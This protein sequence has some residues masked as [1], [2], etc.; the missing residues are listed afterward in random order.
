M[1]GSYI[2]KLLLF[3]SG[4]KEAT[5][6]F[7]DGEV[8]N[9]IRTGPEECQF[10]KEGESPRYQN[11]VFD[12]YWQEYEQQVAM[13]ASE[14]IAL[15]AIKGKSPEEW[16]DEIAYR[17]CD[18]AGYSDDELVDRLASVLVESPLLGVLVGT[19]II[20]DEYFED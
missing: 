18:D 14:G 17:L 5:F 1:D 20:E 16:A 13:N 12:A 7:E 2:A 11:V 19:D 4:L 8:W 15:D 3:E 10:Y 9:F 6:E